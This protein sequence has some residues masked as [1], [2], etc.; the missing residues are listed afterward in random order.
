VKIEIITYGT[1]TSLCRPHSRLLV[2]FWLG[3]LLYKM[4]ILAEMMARPSDPLVRIRFLTFLVD[5]K[6]S[7]TAYEQ[8]SE[9]TSKGFSA[10]NL[11]WFECLVKVV[12]V[13]FNI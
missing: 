6:R 5:T 2:P 7:K 9:L 13:L 1:L 4:H 12:Q 10:N 3:C 11:V 8:A